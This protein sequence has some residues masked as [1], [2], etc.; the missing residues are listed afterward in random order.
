MKQLSL[1]IASLL[2]FFFAVTV[3]GFSQNLCPNPGMEQG[4]EGKPVGWTAEG[5]DTNWEATRPHSGERALKVARPEPTRNSQWTSDAIPV[6]PGSYH[7]SGW[8]KGSR[9]LSPDPSYGVKL[10][11][12][13]YDTN[14][15]ELGKS[16]VISSSGIPVAQNSV[17]YNLLRFDWTY[18]ENVVELKPATASVKLVFSINGV[19][20]NPPVGDGAWLDDVRFEKATKEQID[21]AAQGKGGDLRHDV[22]VLRMLDG[23]PVEFRAA[24]FSGVFKLDEPIELVVRAPEERPDT[25]LTWSVYDGWNVKLATGETPLKR[26]G[27]HLKLSPEVARPFVLL[28]IKCVL[29]S[30]GNPWAQRVVSVVVIPDLTSKTEHPFAAQAPDTSRFPLVRYLGVTM[31]REQWGRIF[32]EMARLGTL[33]P[34]QQDTSLTPDKVAGQVDHVMKTKLGQSLSYLE[35]G[36]EVGCFTE[37]SRQWYLPLWKEFAKAMHEKAPGMKRVFGSLNVDTG[38]EAL[39]KSG[40]FDEAEAVD[41]HYLSTD[42]LKSARRALDEKYGVGKKEILMTE[43]GIFGSQYSQ[44]DY[45]SHL[46]REYASLWNAGVDKLMWCHFGGWGASNLK[47]ELLT[48]G[49]EEG[50]TFVR[51]YTSM[52]RFKLAAHALMVDRFNGLK[53]DGDIP[54]W[55]SGHAWIFSNGTKHAAVVNGDRSRAAAPAALSFDTPVSIE[56]TDIYGHVVTLAPSKSHVLRLS[57]LPVIV[58]WVGPKM[59]ISTTAK[60][61]LEFSPGE[62]SLLP[63]VA[64]AVKL[65]AS[66]A[67]EVALRLPIDWKCSPATAQ[68]V[69]GQ[70]IV[71]HVTAAPGM[72]NKSIRLYAE[73]LSPSHQTLAVTW[74][75]ASLRPPIEVTLKSRSAIDSRGAAIVASIQNSSER[76]VSSQV[77]I[78][79]TATKLDHPFHEEKPVDVAAGETVEVEFP[80]ESSGIDTQR[81][82][83]YP[84][85]AKLVTDG[86]AVA[87]VDTGLTFIG[88]R[89]VADD[90]KVDGDLA[91]YRDIQ[92]IVLERLEHFHYREDAALWKG[93]EDFSGKIH[94]AYNKEGLILAIDVTDDLHYSAPEG[95]GRWIWRCD[96]VE[97]VVATFDPRTA[98][99]TGTYKVTGGINAK[100][101]DIASCVVGASAAKELSGV[102]TEKIPCFGKLTDK[103]YVVEYLIPWKYIGNPPHEPSDV[104]RVGFCLNDY[105]L[106]DGKLIPHGLQSEGLRSSM[107]W[108]GML[109]D[110]TMGAKTLPPLVFMP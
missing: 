43:V 47:Q 84:A 15:R 87:G 69:P 12:F 48:N 96:S 24:P 34:T 35:Y 57:A 105:D 46:F 27:Y 92:P 70:E 100:G 3:T 75:Q 26:D 64:S 104:L 78:T 98:Q 83:P 4:K 59:T 19:F 88:I 109:F 5:A 60:P 89:R 30:Q 82:S 18:V 31:I 86:R 29:S 80:L 2:T 72:P 54:L 10:N 67:G 28:T 49:E 17:G 21:A 71:F 16:E 36:N 85:T 11:L 110:P 14:G 41:F 106:K 22:S 99:I 44:D 8:L 90:W 77:Q 108:G 13:E 23:K 55:N 103:G 97:M 94:M 33:Y 56:V 79:T 63:G 66:E 61:S 9:V 81:D 7:V 40:A 39:L 73:L 45:P 101:L 102:L 32:P 6:T 76:P 37:E 51:S 68:S 91:K 74:A 25:T 58:S 65:V 53:P 20:G 95:F 62:L 93:A 42:F 50:A 38:F 52:P 107:C 1:S